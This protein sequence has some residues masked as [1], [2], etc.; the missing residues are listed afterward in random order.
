MNMKENNM[1]KDDELLNVNGGA[2][3]RVQPNTEDNYMP[4]SY[5]VNGYSVTDAIDAI[6]AR[7]QTSGV[8][9]AIQ[10]GNYIIPSEGWDHLNYDSVE[11]VVRAIYIQHWGTH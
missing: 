9:G 4:D 2:K 1:L 5:T 3:R 8:Y 7:M 11:S 6:S 10:L